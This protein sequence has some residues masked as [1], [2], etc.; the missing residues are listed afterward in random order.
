[1]T[2]AILI[3]GLL[4]VALLAGLMARP[5]WRLPALTVALLAVP[6]NVDDLLPQMLLDLHAV[7]NRV[8]PIISVV[9]LLLLWAVI[10]TI[11]ERRWPRSASPPVLAALAVALLATAAVLAAVAAGADGSAGL[12]GIVV[13]ARIPAL[14]FLG[15][16][17]KD[18]LRD[19]SPIGLA[20]LVG[21]VALLAN[22]VF[23]T[24]SEDLDRFTAKT[25]GRNGF[26]IALTVVS[27]AATGLAYRWWKELRSESRARFVAPA[28][29]GVGAGCLFGLSATG[30]RMALLIVIATAILAVLVNPVR[31]GRRTVVGAV[32][33]VVV[34]AAVL[35]ASAVW[36]EAGARTLSAITNPGATVDAVTE[37]DE[38]VIGPR[39]SLWDLA[40]TMAAEEP[41][42]GVG[43]YQWNIRRYG[44]QARPPVVVLDAHN[45]YLQV[46]AEFGVIVAL[47]YVLLLLMAGLTIAWRLR[48]R[49]ARQRLGWAGLGIVIAS[50]VFPVAAMT[51]SHLFNVRNGALEWLMIAVALGLSSALAAR[52]D[53]RLGPA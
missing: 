32:A 7:P 28:A 3:G 42:H 19:G 24:T 38:A 43:P 35:L 14:L 10:L 21:G 51:N 26:A 47:G 49:L 48:T 41:L 22:G 5:Q 13:F 25:F 11:R 37:A 15:I 53:D 20:L 9:D 30:T 39:R 44:L 34:A 23:T 31:V 18:E 40:I 45:S 29:I 12:R 50:T 8:A 33:T 4:L 46:A 2:I 16:A 52:G 17:L 27:V 1:M 6:G 36:T